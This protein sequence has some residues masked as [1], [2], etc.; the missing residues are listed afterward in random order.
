MRFKGSVKDSE[1]SLEGHDKLIA[2]F[3]SGV[4]SSM[5]RPNK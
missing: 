2:E 1:A 5:R 4:P 3:D